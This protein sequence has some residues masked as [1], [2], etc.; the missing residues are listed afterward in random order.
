MQF[1]AALLVSVLA[2]GCDKTLKESPL[3]KTTSL[4]TMRTHCVGR[5]L[6]DLPAEFEQLL[7]SEVEL[8]YGLGKDFR[9]VNVMLVR[10]AGSV[11][12]FDRIVAKR[13]MELATEPHRRSESKGMLALRRTIDTKT[14]LIRSY[15]DPGMIEY[16]KAEVFAERGVAVGVFKT[17]IFKGEVPEVVESKV[18]SIV[19]K[20]G[21]L[22]APDQPGRGTCLGSLLIDANHDG[23]IFSVAFR[24]ASRPDAFIKI[25]MNSM[26]AKSDGGLLKRWDSKAGMLNKLNFESSSIR[27]GEIALGGNSGEELLLKGKDHGHTV[28]GFTAELLQTKPATFAIPSFAIDMNVGGQIPS[29]EYVD[30]SWSQVEALAI[31]DAI[32]KSIRLRPGAI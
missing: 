5:Y 9:K 19:Q 12:S 14:S 2:S 6:I 18:L 25:D 13:A 16:L 1:L 29:S 24:A 21:F 30:A 23:E 3:D 11:P 32:V 27:R 26:L 7:S 17:D 10:A 31:W 8:I 15:E 4:L 22:S 20:T 28:F